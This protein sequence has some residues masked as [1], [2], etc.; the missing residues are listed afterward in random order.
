MKR[1]NIYSLFMMLGVGLTACNSGGNSS[2]SNS[3]LSFAPASN[4]AVSSDNGNPFTG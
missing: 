3:N 1:N 2:T 4:I